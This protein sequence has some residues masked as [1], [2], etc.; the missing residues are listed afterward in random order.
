MKIAVFKTVI[1]VI[2]RP[3]GLWGPHVSNGLKFAAEMASH[4]AITVFLIPN[5][6]F[7]RKTVIEIANLAIVF[8]SVI[9]SITE[10]TEITENSQL[11]RPW[12]K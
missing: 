4:W 2:G 12:R 10:I 7:K 5:H 3:S 11:Y 9:E 1:S 8:K 6:C